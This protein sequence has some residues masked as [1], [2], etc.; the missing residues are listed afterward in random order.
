MERE[1]SRDTFINRYVFAL[2]GEAYGKI[3]YCVDLRSTVWHLSHHLPCR[4]HVL[5][6]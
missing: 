6:K 2:K 4:T 1:S 3:Y 5:N